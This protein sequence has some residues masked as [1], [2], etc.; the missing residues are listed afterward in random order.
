MNGTA[1]PKRVAYLKNMNLLVSNGENDEKV[2]VEVCPMVLAD[3]NEVEGE[4]LGIHSFPILK[5]HLHEQ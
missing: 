5:T 4:G 2:L 3:V 1:K